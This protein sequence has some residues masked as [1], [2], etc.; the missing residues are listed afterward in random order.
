MSA[1]TIEWLFVGIFFACLF[2]ISLAEGGWLSRFNQV[3]FGKAFAYAF[4][5]NTF[6]ITIGFFVSFVIMAV[7]LML[8]FGGSLQGLSDYDWRL[9]TAVLVASLFP[10]LLLIL[11][12]RLALRIFKMQSVT[13]PWLY[14][15]AASVVFLVLVIAIPTAFVYVA[16]FSGGKGVPPKVG[17][18]AVPQV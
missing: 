3:P 6:A 1:T 12:K 10:I 13:S 15:S 4:A 11:A 8:A 7:L 14:S 5:T 17:A 9:V 16:P 2:A 18:P